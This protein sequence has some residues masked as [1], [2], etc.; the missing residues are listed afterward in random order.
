VEINIKNVAAND[1]DVHLQFAIHDTG[2]GIP[3]EKLASLFD[4]FKQ[5]N[6]SDTRKYGGTGLGLSISK[7]LVELQGGNIAVE[8]TVGSGTTFSFT[9][10]FPK[11][12]P[13]RLAERLGS[14]QKAD[15]SALNGLRI[16]LAD[17]NEYN[18]LVAT[19]ALH[20]KA[21]VL[22]DEA[23]N[24]EEAISMMEQA[25]YDVVLMDV[26]MPVMN[27]LDATMRIRNKLP[28]PKNQTPVI[29]LTASMLRTD[30][31]KCTRAGM[32]T[33]VPKPFK[34]WQLITAIAEVTGRKGI[35]VPPQRKKENTA[36]IIADNIS[37]SDLTY[38]TK[39]CEND[40]KKMK[41]YIRLYLK[42]IPAFKEN[43]QAATAKKDFIE[44]AQHLHTIKPKMMMMGMKATAELAHNMEQLCGERN[45]SAWQQVSVIIAQAD[46]SVEELSDK[47]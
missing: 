17:D 15:G 3:E 13:E 18:R 32:N 12:S 47:C 14:E 34:T 27:G 30:L 28:A 11:G 5:A 39:F 37:I 46:R 16:L 31:D 35:I 7:Q 41:Q 8:S 1:E 26:Q 6:A 25:D 21:D 10:V 4:N 29:A 19:E 2:I 40:Q 23:L 33:Y 44:L 45:E 36:D 24:G 9:L 20:A 22:I 42:A 38:L 43:I